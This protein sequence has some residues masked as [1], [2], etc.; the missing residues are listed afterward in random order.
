MSP[1]YTAYKVY[2]GILAEKLR[3]DVKEKKILP[4]TQSGFKKGRGTMNNVYV[5]Q[6]IVRRELRRKRGKMYGFF[7]DLKAI[8]DRVDRRIL[9]ETMEKKGIRKGIIEKVKEVYKSTKMAVRV[10]GKIFRWL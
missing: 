5:L 2:A 3:K 6:H 7:V 8:F 4:E 1:Y 9:W 10:G